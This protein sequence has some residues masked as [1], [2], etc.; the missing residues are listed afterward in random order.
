MNFTPSQNRWILGVNAPEMRIRHEFAEKAPR[1]LFLV[2]LALELR[3]NFTHSPNRRIWGVNLFSP[4]TRYKGATYAFF[5][6]IGARIA[7][8]F[9]PSQNRWILG[10]NA[11]EMRIR[12]EFAE[13]AP[14][15]LFLVGLALELRLNFTHSPNRRIWGVNLFSPINRYKGA[16]YAFFSRI[17]A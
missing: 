4:I 14:R 2:G 11:P 3:L 6:R 16:T 10:V 9:T 5:S 7:N 8:E 15:I 1:I 17:G 13:K 12:H